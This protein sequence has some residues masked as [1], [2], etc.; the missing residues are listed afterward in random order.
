MK[1][2]IAVWI[3]GGI[4]TGHFSQG[5]PALEKLLVGLS[6]SFEIV[7]YSK[8]PTS[9]DYH[10]SNFIIRSAPAKIKVSVIR[11]CYMI[12]YFLDDHRDNKFH[13]LF[14][15]WGY[16]AGF[17]ATCLSKTVKIPCA[18]YVL[19]SDS[20][21]IASINFGIFHKPLLRRVALWTYKHTSLLL[22]ISEFQKKQLATYG[23]TRTIIIPW[24]ADETVYKF[25]SKRSGSSLHIIH[26][27][28]LT[29]VKDQVTLLKTF[30]LISKQHAAELRILG[31]DFLD[32]TIQKL[33]KDLG[34]DKQVHFLDV[35]PYQQMPE[36]YI[37]ADLML[38]TSMAEG[39]SMA[40]TEAAA[41]GVLLAGTRVGLLH[42]LGED[43][44]ITVDVGDFETLASKVLKV[45]DDN[46]SWNQK[47]QR[48]SQWAE[49]HNLAWTI[50][51]LER[52]LNA[53]VKEPDQ[54]RLPISQ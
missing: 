41:S 40:L 53:L 14:A 43:C 38:H 51:E 21:G 25:L 33:C 19:G 44:G 13:L 3:Y 2:R 48:A 27:G 29:P 17:L 6:S 50:N 23:I 5:Y 20:F 37:W 49:T 52:Q 35:I 15:F 11:W 31:E 54:E 46:R 24:G 34:V 16:P 32:G 28:H 22:G 30:A 8:F 39:Q 45:L 42:D 12:K 4:G 10:S 18:V 26:V 36:Q 9:R 47:I 7:V 1:K